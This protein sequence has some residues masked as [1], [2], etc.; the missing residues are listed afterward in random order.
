MVLA[1]EQAALE[2]TW[3]QAC[4]SAR[5]WLLSSSDIWRSAGADQ[6]VC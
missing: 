3:V 1:E 5:A 6:M 4:D 2:R